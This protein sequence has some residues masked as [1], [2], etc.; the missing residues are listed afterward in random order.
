MTATHA[1]ACAYVVKLISPRP[2]LLSC[3]TPPPQPPCLGSAQSLELQGEVIRLL[4][5]QLV[6][7]P[8]VGVRGGVGVP[9]Q[10]ADQLQAA[11]LQAHA[12][13]APDQNVPAV[14]G[15]LLWVGWAPEL[16]QAEGLPPQGLHNVTLFVADVSQKLQKVGTLRDT[17][18]TQCEKKFAAFI[19][20][21]WS[22]RMCINVEA[23]CEAAPIQ[24]S[25]ISVM[26]TVLDTTSNHVLLTG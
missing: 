26:G 23:G 8:A 6:A 20:G 12:A 13:V 18:G 21:V 10:L 11:A 3:C 4:V 15:L 1:P 16:E 9:G 22:P 5:L 14:H 7:P 2:L 17:S 24:R 19:K 25:I